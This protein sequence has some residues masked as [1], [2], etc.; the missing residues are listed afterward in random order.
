MSNATE[1]VMTWE[2]A[3]TKKEINAIQSNEKAAAAVLSAWRL[4]QDKVAA[5]TQQCEELLKR[6]EGW[7]DAVIELQSHISKL[8]LGEKMTSRPPVPWVLCSEA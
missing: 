6:E 8:E 3:E 4:E 1:I 7:M 5:L 2:D